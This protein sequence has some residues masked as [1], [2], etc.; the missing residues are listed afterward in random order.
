VSATGCVPFVRAYYEA[1]QDWPS[2][3]Q[4]HLVDFV[5]LMTYSDK[6][7]EF[8]KDIIEARSKVANFSNVKLAV[9]AYKLLYLPDVFTKELELCEESG[10]QGW[11]ILHYGSLLQ[12]Q[13]LGDLLITG[14]KSLKNLSSVK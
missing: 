2:W 7:Q 6:P 11:V 5:T 3:I 1:Y 8:K 12:G 10:S 9:G 4:N 14:K 13:A